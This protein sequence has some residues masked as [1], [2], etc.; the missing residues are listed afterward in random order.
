M[1]YVKL[2]CGECLGYK[3]LD[4]LRRR[5]ETAYKC[6][7]HGGSWKP[8]SLEV[9][10]EQE[11]SMH[12][13]DLGP[14]VAQACLL[15]GVDKRFDMWLPAHKIAVEADGKQHFEGKMHNTPA[16]HQLTYDRKIDDL[17][18]EHGLRLVRLHYRDQLSWADCV[19]AAIEAVEADP[20]CVLACY[21]PSYPPLPPT[22]TTPLTV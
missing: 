9:A 17:C 20:S 21:S 10:V 4:S 11:L 7:R 2:D 8:S 3:Q 22:T 12:V 6:G 16:T 5:P 18:W 1:V 14:I 19:A 15:P 13:A